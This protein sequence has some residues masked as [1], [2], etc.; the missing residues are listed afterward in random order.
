MLRDAAYALDGQAWASPALGAVRE[1]SP[2]FWE[3]DQATAGTRVRRYTNR[4]EGDACVVLISHNSWDAPRESRLH[5]VSTNGAAVDATGGRLC[6]AWA[7]SGDA[8]T[9]S[10]ALEA[11]ERDVRAQRTGTQTAV[12]PVALSLAV[13]HR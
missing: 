12:T 9:E 11:A 1:L 2:R 10:T 8:N 7:A 3:L 4:H 13:A 6:V 5:W